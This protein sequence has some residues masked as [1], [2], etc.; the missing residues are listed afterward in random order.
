MNAETGAY[1]VVGLVL[2]GLVLL[3]RKNDRFY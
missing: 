2:V 1:V 3:T